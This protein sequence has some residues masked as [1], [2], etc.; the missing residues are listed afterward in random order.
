V[1]VVLRRQ[2]AFGVV[3]LDGK[4]GAGGRAETRPGQTSWSLP[5]VATCLLIAVLWVAHLS[6]LPVGGFT[7]YDEFYTLDRTVSFSR[8]GD[9][10]T[11]FSGN[12]PSFR[13]PPLQYWMN[14][15]L[16][17]MDVAETAALRLPSMLFALATLVCTA[18]LARVLAP[19]TPW[20]MP[21]SVLLLSSSG[22]FWVYANS[23]M[24][25]IGAAF[26]TT[27]AL[28]LALI[29]VERPRAWYLVAVVLGVGALQK[30]PTALPY[31]AAA[32]FGAWLA[33]R[34]TG[35]A[36]RTVTRDPA[37]RKGTWVALALVLAWPLFQSVRYDFHALRQSHAREMFQR[38]APDASG[39]GR[40]LL[41]FAELVITGEPWLRWPALAAVLVLPFLVRRPSSVMVLAVL[42]FYAVVL[43]AASG[44]VYARYTLTVLP[45]MTAALAVVLCHLSPRPWAGL[46]GSSIVVGL[47]GGPVKSGMLQRAALQP[48]HV[49]EQIEVLR[50]VG[51]EIREDET[52]VYCH[53]A[54][55]TPL[56]PGAVSVYASNGQP[57]LA[58]RQLVNS[59][60]RGLEGP[61]RGICPTFEVPQLAPLLDGFSIVR[62]QAGYVV[63]TATGRR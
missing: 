56:F 63:W 41:D 55:E 62:E 59:A 60:G 3:Q 23:A 7:E 49:A 47:S 15:A 25:D 5:I 29:A 38:F 36:V 20:A 57:I 4:A 48:P 42:V 39:G 51:A 2:G 1:K 22:Q 32:L 16:L 30:A 53:L 46:L 10:L 33:Q 28:V 61:F 17:E 19:Q 14:A 21:L 12:E 44:K 43:L 37:F 52:L 40:D 34:W 9:F 35:F 18:W 27:L 54:G 45:L 31:I 6:A 13:K 8:T 24:L 50:T 26:F 58:S 11:V